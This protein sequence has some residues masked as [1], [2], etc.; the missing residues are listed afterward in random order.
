MANLPE[1]NQAA[2]ESRPFLGCGNRV[3]S[4]GGRR[5]GDS[6]LGCKGLFDKG[7]GKVTDIFW[8]GADAAG[9]RRGGVC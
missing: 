8:D 7:C 4:R 9:G 2:F 5:L 6:P 1:E 3:S